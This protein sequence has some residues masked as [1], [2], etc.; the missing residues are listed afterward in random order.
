LNFFTQLIVDLLAVKYAVRVGH[1]R[2]M[3]LAHIFSALGLILLGILPDAFPDAYT[4]L[5][6]AVCVGAV[7]GGLVEVLVSP[8]VESLPLNEKSGEMSLLH[9]FYSWGYVGVV[10]LSTLYFAVFGTDAWR[11]LPMLWA[12]VPLANTFLLARVPMLPL[13]GDAGRSSVG[14]LLRSGLFRALFALMVCAGAAE[15]CMAQWSSMFAETGLGVSKA[16]GDLF[17][18]CAFAAM[19]GI[20]RT[21]YAK[22]SGSLRLERALTFSGT[23]GIISYAVAIFSEN[24]A[25]SLVGCALSGLAVA[26]LW[27]ATLS[28]SARTYPLGGTA[29]FSVLALAGDVGSSLGP[30]LVGFVAE[31]AR[32]IQY[33]L[34]VG[35]AAMLLI[36]VGV[37]LLK[38]LRKE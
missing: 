38:R 35:M 6:I 13:A 2:G 14:R 34:I 15:E 10:L 4:G 19:M 11:F 24:P 33:G 8:I 21:F 9:S 30:A 31:R 3:I 36:R 37:P 18:P 25:L 20:G 23:L 28:L 27:P 16:L 29:M 1:R 32:D 22:K 7:G 5:L 26:V 17:G 12:I